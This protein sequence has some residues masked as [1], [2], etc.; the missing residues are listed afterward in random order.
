LSHVFLAFTRIGRAAALR[1]SLLMQEALTMG[2]SIG[3]QY[4]HDE[5]ASVTGGVVYGRV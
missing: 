2:I 5:V 3:V 1:R 4:V